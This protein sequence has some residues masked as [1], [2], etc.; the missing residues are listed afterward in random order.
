M[1]QNLEEALLAEMGDATNA[2][3]QTMKLLPKL[4]QSA[5]HPRLRM[6][7]ERQM[8]E[9]EE[10]VARLERAF[11][12]LDRRPQTEVCEGMQ[13]I[14]EEAKEV[15]K[16]AGPGP[17][18]DALMIAA[19]QKLVHYKIATYGTLCAWAD[20]TGERDVLRLLDQSLYEEKLAD[21]MLTRIAESS[22]N[23]ESEEGERRGVWE[24]SRRPRSMRWSERESW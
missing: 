3:R 21:R 8:E 1:I 2:E 18:R 14:L 6:L 23:R 22:A 11:E 15:L 9:I 24:T 7:F 17:V 10:R 16:K 19:A 5:E 4:A 20:E 12:L 13:G